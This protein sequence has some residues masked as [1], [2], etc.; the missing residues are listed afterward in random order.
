MKDA[1]EAS[2]PNIV[3]V[4][5]T[6]GISGGRIRFPDPPPRASLNLLFPNTEYGRSFR[7]RLTIRSRIGTGEIHARPVSLHRLPATHGTGIG[8]PQRNLVPHPCEFVAHFRG[9]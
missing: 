8:S 6:L 3:E 7:D 4:H 1:W 2:K 5:E 9:N